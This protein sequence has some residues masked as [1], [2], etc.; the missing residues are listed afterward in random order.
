MVIA[1]NGNSIFSE[2]TYKPLSILIKVPIETK[3]SE[4]IRNTYSEIKKKPF[5]LRINEIA[6][7]SAA[8]KQ[9]SDCVTYSKLEVTTV[10][11]IAPTIQKT[12]R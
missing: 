11:K 5:L 8:L 4:V 12:M 7:S 9:T 2:S 6:N 10:K 3:H 1:I